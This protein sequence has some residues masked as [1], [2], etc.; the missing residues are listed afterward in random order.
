MKPVVLA[1][2][3][4]V[5]ISSAAQ[6]RD[7]KSL[8]GQ[9]F[10]EVGGGAGAVHAGSFEFINPQGSSYIATFPAKIPGVSKVAGNDIVLDSQRRDAFSS[11]AEITVG[12]FVGD[13]VYLRATYRY[14]GSFH[15]SGS[16]AF[17]IDPTIP[18]AVGFDQD[19]SL[20]GHAAYLGI[21]YQAD[22]TGALFVDLSGEASAAR[23]RSVS[24]QGANVGDPLGHPARTVTNFS[25]GGEVGL[26]VHLGRRYDLIFKGRAD[27]LGTAMTGVVPTDTVSADGNYGINAGEQLKLHRLTSYGLAMTLRARF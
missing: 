13:R 18:L 26:G 24:R 8:A 27:L 20:R 15:L 4:A 10:I 5:G 21:G 14:L 6:A 23:L 25:A 7:D 17:P 11:T 1:A 22:L 3:I 16:T 19:Y 12:H 2:L 9:S